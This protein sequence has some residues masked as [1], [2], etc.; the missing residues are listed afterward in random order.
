MRA[1]GAWRLATVW[2]VV[3]AVSL[4]WNVFQEKQQFL[5]AARI[6]A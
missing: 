4:V 3:V 2:A 1:K 5:E 6:Q